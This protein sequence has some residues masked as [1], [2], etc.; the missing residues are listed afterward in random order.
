MLLNGGVAEGVVVS[1]NI[2]K[3]KIMA[4]NEWRDKY[5]K[6]IRVLQKEFQDT[7]LKAQE[8]AEANAAGNFVLQFFCI[9]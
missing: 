9:A 1:L 4:A 3:A 7:V 2:T 5:E 6:I 8:Q